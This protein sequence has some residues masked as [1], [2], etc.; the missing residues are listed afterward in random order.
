LKKNNVLFLAVYNFLLNVAATNLAEET[1]CIQLHPQQKNL[2]LF[3]LKLNNKGILN[4]HFFI[5]TDE[6]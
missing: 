6:I 4:H 5:S 3:R 1:L 2:L